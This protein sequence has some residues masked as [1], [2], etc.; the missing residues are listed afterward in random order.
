ML[1]ALFSVML[2]R[3]AIEHVADRPLEPP[4]MV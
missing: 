1:A 3:A 2:E 4:L